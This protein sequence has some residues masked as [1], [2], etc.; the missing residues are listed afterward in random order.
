MPNTETA[1]SKD[2]VKP[3]Q[4]PRAVLVASIAMTDDNFTSAS[5]SIWLREAPNKPKK[6]TDTS[7]FAKNFSWTQFVLFYSKCPKIGTPEHKQS[8]AGDQIRLACS[9]Q[10]TK[11]DEVDDQLFKNQNIAIISL[12]ILHMLH[13]LTSHKIDHIQNKRKQPFQSSDLGVVH[14]ITWCCNW[15]LRFSKGDLGV[16]EI[17]TELES[18]CSFNAAQG[19]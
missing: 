1:T 19:T 18:F 3:A 4:G 15:I 14:I 16:Q 10:N 9:R 5:K 6:F 2:V 7:R 12:W 11:V 17:P 8:N 13:Y